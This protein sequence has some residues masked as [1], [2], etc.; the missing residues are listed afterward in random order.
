[1][2]KVLIIQVINAPHTI[3]RRD[4]AVE[5]LES[6]CKLLP[7]LLGPVVRIKTEDLEG[8]IEQCAG[9]GEIS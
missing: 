4:D 2:V 7:G 9:G 3:L 8:L 6:D 5:G 1:V